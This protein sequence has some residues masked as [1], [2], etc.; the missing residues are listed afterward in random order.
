MGQQDEPTVFCTGQFNDWELGTMTEVNVP[1]NER[2][3]EHKYHALYR[4]EAQVDGGQIYNY[5]FLINGE[6]KVSEEANRND[7]GT[8]NWV[9]VK[10][11]DANQDKAKV[12]FQRPLALR[13]MKL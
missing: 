2:T 7:R 11:S 1:V 12:L 3:D 8:T 5:Y 10:L 4:Y 13:L 6:K 9:F